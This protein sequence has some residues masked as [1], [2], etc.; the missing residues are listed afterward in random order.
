LRPIGT[1]VLSFKANLPFTM[2]KYNEVLRARH[3]GLLR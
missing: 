3:F 1:V 2:V